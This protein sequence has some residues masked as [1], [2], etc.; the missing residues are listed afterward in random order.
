MHLVKGQMSEKVKLQPKHTHQN[1][2]SAKA[3]AVVKRFLKVTRWVLNQEMKE[4]SAAIKLGS[5]IITF[6]VNF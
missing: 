1:Q 2:T 6:R 4:R 3:K 5:R